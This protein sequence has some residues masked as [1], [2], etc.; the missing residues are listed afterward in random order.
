[1]K[2]YRALLSDYEKTRG[3]KL[4]VKKYAKHVDA[5]VGLFN[6]DSRRKLLGKNPNNDLDFVDNSRFWSDIKKT[7]KNGLIDIQLLC[8]IANSA[9]IKKIFQPTLEDYPKQITGGLLTEE[10]ENAT[11]TNLTSMIDAILKS[12]TMNVDPKSDIW[13]AELAKRI[14]TICLNHIIENNLIDSPLHKEHLRL[15]DVI[16]NSELSRYDKFNTKIK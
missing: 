7:T 11:S 13:S 4:A 3:E 2:D 6:R 14:I 12:A 8:E 16:L 9:Q 1:M 5:G 15:V 10:E